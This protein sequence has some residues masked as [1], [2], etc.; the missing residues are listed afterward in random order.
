M[1]FNF[2]GFT[3]NANYESLTVQ[4]QHEE[5]P[6]IS[7]TSNEGNIKLNVLA[8]KTLGVN[9]GLVNTANKAEAGVRIGFR[10]QTWAGEKDTLVCHLQPIGSKKGVKLA[11][12][13]GQNGGI[14]QCSSANAW[15]TLKGNKEKLMVYS[16]NEAEAAILFNEADGNAIMTPAQGEEYGV[17]SNGCWTQL[18]VDNGLCDAEDLGTPAIKYFKMTFVKDEEKREVAA[19]QKAGR[20]KMEGGTKKEKAKASKETPATKPFVADEGANDEGEEQFL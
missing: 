4:V 14:L 13:G 10:I 7:T 9:Y 11:S 5:A 19:S 15:A 16:I 12:T 17:T 20:P 6:F 1:E 3:K 2:K 18:A 8:C